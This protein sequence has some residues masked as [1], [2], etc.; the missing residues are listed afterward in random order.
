M[1]DQKKERKPTPQ[2]EYLNV[3]LDGF[4]PE[5][6]QDEAFWDADDIGGS[7]GGKFQCRVDG[8]IYRWYR[9]LTEDSQSLWF[10]MAKTQSDFVRHILTRVI[11]KMAS[12]FSKTRR[13]AM[14]YMQRMQ[15]NTRRAST[16]T[17]RQVAETWARDIASALAND[18]LAGDCESA[19]DHFDTCIGAIQ[20]SLDPDDV[21][22]HIKTLFK[23]PDM[24]KVMR[25]P[26]FHA[27]S[28]KFLELEDEYGD[29]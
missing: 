29:A 24:R 10:G 18:I 22:R 17:R 21:V 28:A 14:P 8:R 23:M 27:A 11:A 6:K 20:E 15:A 25:N 13:E 9:E 16:E 3:Y 12:D 1:T 5:L 19:A 26:A 4:L 7:A 2:E